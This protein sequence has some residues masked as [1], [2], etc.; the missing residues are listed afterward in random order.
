MNSDLKTLVEGILDDLITA[1]F[2]ADVLT[3]EV[4]E[5]YKA[6]P[7][8]R[9]MSIPS[10]N[11]SSVDVDLRFIFSEELIDNPKEERPKKETIS[12]EFAKSVGETVL[13]QPSVTK[14]LKT[15]GDRT[16]FK[17][18][19]LADLAKTISSRMNEQPIDRQSNI[20][21]ELIKILNTS[22]IKLSSSEIKNIHEAIAISDLRY[23]VS[24]KKDTRSLPRVLV[25]P[26]SLTNIVPEAISR[27]SFKVDLS[28]RR[29]QALEDEKSEDDV[30]FYL[31]D[32]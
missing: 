10:L 26:N 5:L 13:S 3:V 23:I 2:Q 32:E 22:K 21:D 9:E 1:R 11:I 7:I 12:A 4:S 24:A 29:W 30:K 25:S 20:K 18:K 16:K 17:N 8:M 31:T 28:G 19:L 27:I 14:S 15:K 6:H